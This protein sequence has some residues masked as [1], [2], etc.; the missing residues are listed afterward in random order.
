MTLVVCL[1]VLL[2]IT[3]AVSCKQSID[4][5]WGWKR[6]NL[7]SPKKI[8]AL[9]KTFTQLSK[10]QN[11]LCVKYPDLME[12]IIRGATTGVKECERQLSINRWNCSNVPAQGTLFGPVL[13]V[14]CKESAFLYAITAAGVAH[15]ITSACSSGMYASCGCDRSLT[16]RPS[17][18]WEWRGCHSN[19]KFAGGLTK[20]FSATR[21]SKTGH[22]ERK[23]MNRHNIRAGI[24]ALSKLLYRKCKCH[25]VC[26]SCEIKTCWMQ[27]PRDFESVG[28]RLFTR[29]K[30]AI[31]MVKTKR[32]PRV[33]R[34]KE[35]NAQKPSPDD[36]I[37]FQSSPNFCDAHAR[38]G[39]PG[40][41]GRVCNIS[42]SDIDSC[43]IL[44]CGR[45][46]NVQVVKETVNCNCRFFWCCHVKCDK[47]KNMREIYTCK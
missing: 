15:S 31:E 16:G 34:V 8:T 2:V 33:L 4:N 11:D 17:G 35:K 26:G 32:G 22:A 38:I 37:Y 27:H 6:E 46:Y 7:S 1:S 47:C 28:K 19:V 36:L 13:P 23:K 9:C 40:T 24:K 20:E 5:S 10:K 30:T 18:D 25:G 14:G 44:C 3:H 29:Y 12:P 43:S 21:V 39:T 42:S 45:G 41:S